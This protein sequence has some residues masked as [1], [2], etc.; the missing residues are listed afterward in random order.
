MKSIVCTKYGAPDV[1]EL[2]DIAKPKPKDNEVL[3]KIHAAS[4]TT[5][6]GMMRTGKPYIGRL[7]M[8]FWKPKS[9]TPGTGF[10]GM[11]ESIGKNVTQFE[12]GESVFGESIF[13]LGTNAEYVCVPEQGVLQ[14]LPKNMS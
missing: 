12:K 2:K 10:A 1:L 13:G 6:D 8:G 9:V 3:I 4:V 5:A 11:I 14:R 7:F